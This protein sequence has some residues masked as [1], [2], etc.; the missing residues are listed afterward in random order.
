MHDRIK[1]GQL[2]DIFHIEGSYDYGR[3]QKLTDGWR[4]K[5]PNYSVTLGGGIHLIDLIIWLSGK[6][7]TYVSGVGNGLATSESHF[8]GLSLTSASI[9]FDDGST[10]QITSNYASVT[11]HHHKLCIYGTNGTFEQSHLGASYYWSRDPNEQAEIVSSPYSGG[12]KG[13]FV[14]QF[15]RL[16]S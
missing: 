16:Y 6:K 7:I 3:L 9:E 14:G 13:R 10:A 12:T 1:S 4:G 15:Y 8:D 11:P 5:V 2:G